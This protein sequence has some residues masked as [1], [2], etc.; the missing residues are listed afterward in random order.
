MADAEPDV[1]AIEIDVDLTAGDEI[2]RM[3]VVAAADDEFAVV[4]SKCLPSGARSW[5][6]RL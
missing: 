6:A 3:S 2:H 5:P 1:L 4:N